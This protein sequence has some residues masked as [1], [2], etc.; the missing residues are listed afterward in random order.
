MRAVCVSQQSLTS[1]AHP[2]ATLHPPRRLPLPRQKRGKGVRTS[3]SGGMSVT[4]TCP[5]AT[6]ATTAAILSVPRRGAD[7]ARRERQGPAGA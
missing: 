7:E 4:T 2:L 6:V 3:A 1:S 5:V